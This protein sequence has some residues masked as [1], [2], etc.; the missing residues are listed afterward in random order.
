[1]KHIITASILLTVISFSA[2]A[3]LSKEDLKEIEALLI[4]SEKRTREYIDLKVNI[5]DTKITGMTETINAKIDSVEKQVNITRNF[6][7]A[8]I[9]LIAVAITAPYFLLNRQDDRKYEELRRE[10]QALKEENH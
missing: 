9:A 8:L 7:I 3:E 1:M 2:A 10:I 5:I 6:I 4:A